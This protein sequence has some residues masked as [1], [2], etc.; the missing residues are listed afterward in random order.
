MMK[1]L[2]CFGVAF[3]A[4]SA[5]AADTECMTKQKNAASYQFALTEIIPVQDVKVVSIDHGAWTE[6]V[7]DN[8]GSNL[9]VVSGSG[10]VN[11]RVKRKTYRVSA[12]QIGVSSDCNIT[13]VTEE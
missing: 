9:V 1:T 6:A 4:Q 13:G 3:V 7:G 5:F 10:R 8:T 12:K 2:I 11:A